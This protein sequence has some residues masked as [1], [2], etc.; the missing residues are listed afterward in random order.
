[1][2]KC[3]HFLLCVHTCAAFCGR[4]EKNTNF[5]CVHLIKKCLLLFGSVIIVDKSNFIFGNTHY[6]KLFLYI[7]I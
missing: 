6:H 5:T 1:M 3:Y 4:A 7:V 2:V